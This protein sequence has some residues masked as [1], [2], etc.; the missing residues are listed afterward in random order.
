MN[1]KENQIYSPNVVFVRDVSKEVLIDSVVSCFGIRKITPTDINGFDTKQFSF[2][3]AEVGS[4]W[5]IMDNIYYSLYN[6][7]NYLS[8]IRLLG[9]EKEVIQIA[10]GDIDFSYEIRFYK[11]GELK[12]E[13]IASNTSCK[14]DEVKTEL[15]YGKA[16]KGEKYPI[17][18]PQMFSILRYSGL[19][20]KRADLRYYEYSIS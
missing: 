6:H 19:D 4:W 1:N 3:L 15:N 20:I 8:F 9:D 17:D 2:G 11:S 18:Y 5:G 14:K 13:L 7:K 16:L 10:I 12:R